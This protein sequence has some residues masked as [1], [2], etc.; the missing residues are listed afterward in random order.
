MVCV[1]YLL[2]ALR[3][4]YPEWSK[5]GDDSSLMGFFPFL[6][7]PAFRAIGEMVDR[8]EYRQIELVRV[9]KKF[10]AFEI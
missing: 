1:E 9:S 3:E 4:G 8:W 6:F 2:K 7:E 10:G 5:C